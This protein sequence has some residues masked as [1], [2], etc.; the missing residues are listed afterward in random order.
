MH[1]MHGRLPSLHSDMPMSTTTQ[2][3]PTERTHA[4]TNSKAADCCTMPSTMSAKPAENSTKDAAVIERSSREAGLR[5]AHT[6]NATSV[7]TP[8]SDDA[9]RAAGSTSMYCG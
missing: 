8:T 9:S 1:S 6:A 2:R 4:P 7:A 3:D 5:S